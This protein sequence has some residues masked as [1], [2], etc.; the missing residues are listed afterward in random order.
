MTAYEIAQHVIHMRDDELIA[1]LDELALNWPHTY[2]EIIATIKDNA[3]WHIDEEQT[4]C[5]AP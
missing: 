1:V 5:K 2:R 3:E 4:T